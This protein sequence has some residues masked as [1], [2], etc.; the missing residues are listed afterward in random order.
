M[1]G[2]RIV[3]RVAALACVLVGAG[4]CGATFNPDGLS[5]TPESSGSHEPMIESVSLDCIGRVDDAAAFVPCDGTDV[6]RYGPLVAVWFHVEGGKQ[7]PAEQWIALNDIEVATK[8]HV[9]IDDAVIPVFALADAFPEVRR[10]IELPAARYHVR[11][12]VMGITG[13]HTMHEKDVVIR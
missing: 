7:W 1:A 3:P 4:A 9:T 13:P 5:Y 10:G 11:V 8:G 2:W 12:Q 6:P